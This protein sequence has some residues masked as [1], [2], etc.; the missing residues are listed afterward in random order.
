MGQSPDSKSY[1]TN[2]E[3]VPLIQGNADVTN[4]EPNPKNYTK[5]PTKMC[6]INDILLSVR[7]PVGA[8]CKT[9]IIACLG[10]GMCS[11][12][13]YTNLEYIYQFL[14]Y[15]EDKW[16]KI[17]QGSTF[18]SVSGDEIKK[19]LVPINKNIEYISNVLMLQDEKI[20]LLYDELEQWKQK[21]KSLM[22]LLLTGIVRCKD[23]R[24]RL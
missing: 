13:P 16:Q 19:I 7:A 17:S 1:N 22:Q 10:R 11:I 23:D 15:Y 21:K 12:R 9:N 8:V 2:K 18:E 6:K 24:T 4:R 14:L 3:G 5:E 20:A